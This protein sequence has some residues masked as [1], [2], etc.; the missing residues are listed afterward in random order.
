MT[1]KKKNVKTI[2]VKTSESKC[3]KLTPIFQFEIMHLLLK[4]NNN[5]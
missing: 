4:S 5:A 1:L 3:K 2:M